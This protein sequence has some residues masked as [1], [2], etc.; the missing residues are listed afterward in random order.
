MIGVYFSGTGNTKH[1]VEK[2]VKCINPNAETVSIE[3]TDVIVSMRKHDL[4]VFGYPI[5]YSRLP[6]IVRDFIIKNKQVFCGKKIYIISTQGTF[7]GD[8][9][10]GCSARLFKKFGA[11]IIGGLHLKMPDNVLA[12][13]KGLGSPKKF[14]IRIQKAEQKI[15]LSADKYKAGKP[16]KEGL[17]FIRRLIGIF[18]RFIQKIIFFGKTGYYMKMPN[19][20]VESCI[21]CGLCVNLCPMNNLEIKNKK[22]I[23][24]NKCTLCYRCIGRCPKKA[25][26]INGKKVH[27]Q[28]NFENYRV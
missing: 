24:A 7:S 3:S 9:S 8:D 23:S 14:E 25:L 2:F 12:T 6:G 19:V 21:G 13:I 1:C 10:A 16:S 22:V 15:K 28:Y 18:M 26:T 4:I 20:N 17:R 5:Y 11:K 27:I